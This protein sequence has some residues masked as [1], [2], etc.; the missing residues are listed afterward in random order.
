MQRYQ[1]TCV[2][3]K[4]KTKT[5]EI[6]KLQFISH[7]ESSC[8]DAGIPAQFWGK[9]MMPYLSN[10]SRK[11]LRTFSEEILTDWVQ[12]KKNY[13]AKFH[14]TSTKF[15]QLYVD[16]RRETTETCVQYVTRLENLLM[17]YLNLKAVNTVKGLVNLLVSDRM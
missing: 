6:D 14:L 7:F 17:L 10:Q 13:F 12:L 3:K 5:S 4:L 8:K 11:L 2:T 16:A 15:R 9:L 1:R